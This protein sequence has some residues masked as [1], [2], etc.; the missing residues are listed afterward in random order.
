MKILELRNQIE[1]ERKELAKYEDKA[2]ILKDSIKEKEK[3]L[4]NLLEDIRNKLFVIRKPRMNQYEVKL[5]WRDR[6]HNRIFSVYFNKDKQKFWLQ[7]IFP[8]Q[9]KEFWF[10]S[11]YYHKILERAKELFKVHTNRIFKLVNIGYI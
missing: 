3:K 11:D 9:E 4:S 1:F 8:D 10:E 2:I 5:L 6:K 7:M